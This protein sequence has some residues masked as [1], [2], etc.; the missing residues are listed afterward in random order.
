MEYR[1]FDF[2]LSGRWGISTNFIED[3]GIVRLKT[4]SSSLEFS[5]KLD[6]DSSGLLNVNTY[7]CTIDFGQYNVTFVGETSAIYS[8]LHA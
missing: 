8:T 4:F 1:N 5:V 6:T 7:N 2:G 3:R